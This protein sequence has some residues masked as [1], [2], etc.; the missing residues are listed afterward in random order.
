MTTNNTKPLKP[1]D[2]IDKKNAEKLNSKL[3]KDIPLED[4][5][6]NPDN[7]KLFTMENVDGLC[8]S[9]ESIG[10]NGAIEVYRLP[11]GKYQISSGHRRYAAMKRL[12]RKTIPCIV[13]EAENDILVRKK[14]V[15]SNINTRVLSPIEI[16]R[17]IQYYENILREENYR[18][19][20]INSRLGEI[21]SISRTKV[22]KL[23]ALLKLAD[24]IQDLAKAT[25]FPFEAFEDAVNFPADKQRQLAENLR[26]H[27]EQNPNAEIDTPVVNMYIGEIKKELALEKAKKDREKAQE[28]LQNTRD[29]IDDKIAEKI[30]Q[31][32]E[33]GVE[34][35]PSE[36]DL[37]DDYEKVEELPMFESA[38]SFPSEFVVEDD[39]YDDVKDMPMA[40]SSEKENDSMLYAYTDRMEVELSRV[41]TVDKKTKD[42]L[43][44]KLN[45]IIR[46]LEN[47]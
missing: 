38:E 42:T 15:E 33:D 31:A 35:D 7:A 20:D 19:G 2:K 29:L 22:T 23:K 47:M 39:G 44:K 34:L 46:M 12:K 14:L 3:I 26:K 16:A 45:A 24:E 36:I 9:I 37:T 30:N 18:G 10:F 21:F 28:L 6:P 27:L 17:A 32:A 4:I 5:V 41:G 25:N 1:L 43:I 8:Q 13:M 40:F 11:S